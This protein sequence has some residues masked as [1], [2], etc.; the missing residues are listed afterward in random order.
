MLL[1][2]LARMLV[3]RITVGGCNELNRRAVPGF[4]LAGNIAN[5]LVE[6]NGDSTGLFTFCSAS[7]F[8]LAIRFDFAAG[9]INDVTINFD[10]ATFD[11]SIGFAS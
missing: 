5:R 8:N 7:E 1:R 10:P 11:V 4:G 9:N 6:Q 3:L 2:E